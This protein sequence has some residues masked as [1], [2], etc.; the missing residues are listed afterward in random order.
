MNDVNN[1]I[2]KT[3]WH[4]FQLLEFDVLI[5]ENLKPWIL[6]FNNRPSLKSVNS[7]EHNLNVE[8]LPQLLSIV[9]PYG[10]VER[11]VRTTM[12]DHRN[13]AKIF[14]GTHNWCWIVEQA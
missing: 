8:M 3:I 12:V 11:I 1:V 2:P 6:E 10:E 9:D 13:K 7:A 14:S 4:C 5:D